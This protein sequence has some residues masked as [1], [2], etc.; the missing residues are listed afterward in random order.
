MTADLS[1]SVIEKKPKNP[2]RENFTRCI[3]S[4]IPHAYRFYILTLRGGE[5]AHGNEESSS[6]EAGKKGGQEEVVAL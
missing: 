1:I 3:N 4:A 6:E 2:I 5:D